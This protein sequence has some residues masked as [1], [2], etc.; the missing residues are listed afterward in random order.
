MNPFG[1]QMGEFLFKA[2]PY[3]FYGAI[4]AFFV[5]GGILDYH[6]RKYGVGFLRLPVF[7]IFYIGGGLLLIF[8]MSGAYYSLF[9]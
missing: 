9:P 2:L 7:R 8:I 5:L 3:L 1:G 4:I 6:W